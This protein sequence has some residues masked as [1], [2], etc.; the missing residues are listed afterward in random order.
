MYGDDNE[1]LEK[2]YEHIVDDF[3]MLSKE[4]MTLMDG[5][6]FWLIPLGVKGD[7]PFLV[8]WHFNLYRYRNEDNNFHPQNGF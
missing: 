3:E 4:G 2:F 1:I 5:E 6:P 7:W 8:L